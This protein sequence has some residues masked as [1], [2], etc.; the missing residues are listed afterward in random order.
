MQAE[1][2]Q[3]LTDFILK[4]KQAT[5]VGGGSKLLPYRLGSH[6]LQYQQGDWIYHD[7]YFGD[8]DFIGGEIVY[9]SRKVVWGMNYYGRI[10][11]PEKITSAIAGKIIQRS[12]SEMYRSGRFLGG[13]R[14]AVDEFT[15]TDTNTG[16]P[17][18]FTGREWIEKN[19]EIV[20]ALDYHG[21]LIN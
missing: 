12:L 1:M 14:H 15:Y 17:S 11:L 21:G 6:D 2:V 13:F 5:Y 3:E 7:C 10:L 19:G 18:Y 9:R 16:D 8:S 20:Y 4:A